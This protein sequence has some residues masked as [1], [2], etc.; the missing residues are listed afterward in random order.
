MERKWRKLKYS[1]NSETSL[2]EDE[3]DDKANYNVKLEQ[4]ATH[5]SK[6]ENKK[7][8]NTR[9]SVPQHQQSTEPQL[10]TL[11]TDD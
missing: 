1:V 11:E 3:H 5:E 4:L 6:S 8:V 7:N 9:I 10:S 2:R